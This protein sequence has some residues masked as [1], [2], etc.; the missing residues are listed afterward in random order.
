MK[1]GAADYSTA[2]FY[3]FTAILYQQDAIFYGNYQQAATVF[4]LRN[5]RIAR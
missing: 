2:P 5:C 4:L 1:K 3:F